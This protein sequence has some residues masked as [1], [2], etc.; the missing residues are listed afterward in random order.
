MVVFHWYILYSLPLYLNYRVNAPAEDERKVRGELVH[1]PGL[2]EMT[3]TGYSEGNKIPLLEWV[4]AVVV[5][6][7]DSQCSSFLCDSTRCVWKTVINHVG[8]PKAEANAR[9]IGRW[10]GRWT[11]LPTIPYH[12]I[13]ECYYFRPEV[14]HC[15]HHHGNNM[16]SSLPLSL[17]IHFS[18][19]KTPFHSWL[20]T[21]L[22]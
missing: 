7:A 13:T 9:E 14:C 21:L 11:C 20:W 4:R 2:Q 10:R 16:I 12:E 17:I 8:W 22:S 6:A 1:N 15:V 18:E 3:S 5:A 19:I